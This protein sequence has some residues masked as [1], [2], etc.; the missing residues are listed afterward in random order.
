MPKLSKKKLVEAP[1]EVTAP[2]LE[3][4]APVMAQESAPKAQ[5]TAPA[6]VV[7]P[8]RWQVLAGVQF[9]YKGQITQLVP[10]HVMREDLYEHGFIETAKTL[11][12]KLKEVVD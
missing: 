3:Q 10:G 11:G 9:S 8:K 1:K 12:L 2:A 4:T 5:K 6:P 7:K